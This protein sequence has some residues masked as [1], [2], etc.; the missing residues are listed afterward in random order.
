MGQNQQQQENTERMKE[1]LAR[2]KKKYIVLSGKGGVGKST[3][4]V[5]LAATLNLMGKKVGILDVDIHGP[6][7]AKMTG[8]SG[9]RLEMNKAGNP[10]PLKIKDNFYVL[11]IAALLESDDTPVVWRGPLKM[12]AIKQFLNDIEWPELDYLIIDC[13]PGTGDEPLSAVQLIG[14][15]DGSIIVS[16]P[17]E[18][19]FLD[20]RKTINFSKML[21]V[22]VVGIVENMSG[23]KCP[24]CGE[25]TYIFKEGG[26]EKAANDFGVDILGKVPFEIEMVESG[27]SGAFYVEKYPESEGAKVYR[28]IANKV[29]S[30]EGNSVQTTEAAA[31]PCSACSSQCSS[32]S[33]GGDKMKVAVPLANGLLCM[34]FGHAEQFGLYEVENGK[35]V[36]KEFVTPPQ[37]EPGVIPR[38][39]NSLGVNAIIAGGMG[40]R[41]QQFF[42]EF[43][44]K[45]L[46]G[47]QAKTP[48]QLIEDMVKGTLQLGANVC[49]H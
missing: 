47:A 37:H 29:M 10:V 5:N 2:I 27:D 18:V 9:K 30:K 12:T 39:L 14:Q 17:Q 41:A 42:N 22:P 43:G 1:N 48:E 20:A 45:V 15:V 36:N 26:A 8:I 28:E 31:S 11:T 49:D 35:I 23:F 7:I 6:S 4:S 34:H 16:T 46:V 13:P 33:S 21:K 3:V 24:K 32:T 38:W 19:A 25:I 40:S 44:I